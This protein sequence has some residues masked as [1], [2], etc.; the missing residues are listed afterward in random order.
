MRSIWNT[1]LNIIAR[2]EHSSNELRKKLIQRFPEDDAE[3][4]DVLQRLVDSNLQSD[5]R[6][7]EMWLRYQI[8]KNRGPIR[9]RAE[10]RQ[11]GVEEFIE[12]ALLDIEVDWFDMA[13]DCATRKYQALTDYKEKGKAYRFLAYRGFENDSISFAIDQLYRPI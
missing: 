1:A 11:K 6:F 5:H 2:R 12:Q 13:L 3:I 8:S 9:I 4:S 10:A 7:T